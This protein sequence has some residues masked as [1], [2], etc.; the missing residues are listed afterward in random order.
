MANAQNTPKIDILRSPLGRA[1]GVGSAKHGGAEWLAVRLFSVLLVPLSLWFIFSIINLAGASHDD[2][3]HWMSSPCVM[4]LM[5][6]LVILTFH[7]LEHGL[8]SVIEDYVHKDAVRLC[9]L[10]ALKGVSLLLALMCI[11]S[12]LK[13]GL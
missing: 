12:V 8:R 9:S 2:V 3:I 4:A 11:V 1:R 10:L 6:A 7:H 5:I 13:I